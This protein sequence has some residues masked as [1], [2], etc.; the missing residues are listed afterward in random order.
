MI[1]STYTVTGMTCGH[2]VNAVSTELNN[3]AGVTEVNVVLGTGAVSVIS[4]APLEAG[5]VAA[6]VKEAGYELAASGSGAMG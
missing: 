1:N 2:C 4:Q 3:L 5:Q 6:A